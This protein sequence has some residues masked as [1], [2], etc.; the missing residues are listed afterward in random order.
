MTASATSPRSVRPRWRPGRATVIAATIVT[1]AGLALFVQFGVSGAGTIPDAVAVDAALADDLTAAAKSC[2]SLSPA[3]LAG[4]VMAKTG[5]VPTAAG[6]IAGLTAAQWAIW[7]PTKDAAPSDPAASVLALAHLTCDLIGQIRVSGLIGNQ[8]RLAVAA[9]QS[10][11]EAVN[12]AGGVPPSVSAFVDRTSAYADFYATQPFLGGPIAPGSS[13]STSAATLDPTWS[14]TPTIGSTP[15]TGSTPTIGSTAT[16]GSTPTAGPSHTA[17]ITQPKP[18]PTASPTSA[19][20]T[21]VGN[22]RLKDYETARCLD[23]DGAGVVFTAICDST[24]NQRWATFTTPF[25]GLNYLDPQTNRCLDSNAAGDIYT[26]PCNWN[27]TYQAW[28]LGGHGPAQTV[29]DIQTLRCLDSNRA[30]AAYTSPCNWNNTFQN[31]VFEPTP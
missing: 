20:G 17:P 14:A 23:S 1:L 3:Q 29:Q 11:V 28:S 4:Q 22:V 6:G 27:N 26:S 5:F 24:G 7:A 2:P 13:P 8:W 21:L 15:T 10:S 9:W 31:W 12:D 19:P 16:S 30:G 25:S 18:S